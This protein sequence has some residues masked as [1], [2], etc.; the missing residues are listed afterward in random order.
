MGRVKWESAHSELAGL[1]RNKGLEIAW[2]A[3]GKHIVAGH[4]DPIAFRFLKPNGK[5]KDL[6]FQQPEEQTNRFAS[7]L[8]RLDLQK[9]DVVFSLSS[10]IEELELAALGALKQRSVFCPLFSAFGPEPIQARTQKG[11]GR[12][13]VT[14]S[15]LYRRK[16]IAER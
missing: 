9:G 12:V 16:H 15:A 3:I 6:N 8:S 5:Q 14:T 13:L 7:A 4:G 11:D 2:E 1:P 10:R